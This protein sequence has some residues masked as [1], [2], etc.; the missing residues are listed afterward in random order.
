MRRIDFIIFFSIFLT[1][2]G[3]INFYVFVSGLSALPADSGLRGWYFVL[4]WFLVAAFL[5]GRFL[6]RVT[7]SWLSTSLIWIGSFWFAAMLYFV[8]MVA[9]IDLARLIDFL[10][11]IFPDSITSD[12]SRTKTLTMIA[13]TTA[14]AL[15]VGTGHINARFHRIQRL[16]FDLGVKMPHGT[17]LT[18]AVASDI[19]L[20]T[21]IC[22]SR[23]EKI[24]DEINAMNPDII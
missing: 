21:I 8:L 14:C 3:L 22:K 23:F 13:V 5:L 4:F 9:V 11:P 16:S 20:G 6:E 7:I 24:V 12:P 1:V 10:F 17:Q 19:H 18:L 15:V 2:Y